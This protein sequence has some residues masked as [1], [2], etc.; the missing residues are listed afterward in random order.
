MF[1][2][3]TVHVH[4]YMHV[5]VMH[6]KYNNI[7]YTPHSVLDMYLDTHNTHV[8]DTSHTALLTQF[9]YHMQLMIINRTLNCISITQRG[10]TPLITAARFGKCDVV[11]DLLDSGADVNAQDYVRVHV[12]IHK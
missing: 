5:H 7:I 1:I 12:Y 3:Y 8:H 2:V 11:L 4:V 9:Q 10:W 6:N